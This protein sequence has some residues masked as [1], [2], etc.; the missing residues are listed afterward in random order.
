MCLW[1]MR[2]VSEKKSVVKDLLSPFEGTN[3]VVYNY[4]GFFNSG[5][6]V[7]KLAQMKTYVA[8]TI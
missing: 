5:P 7:D 6:L 1:R 3:H 8:G 4:D 2:K